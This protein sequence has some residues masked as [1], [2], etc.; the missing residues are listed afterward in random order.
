MVAQLDH[1]GWVYLK[2]NSC[3]PGMMCTLQYRIQ[4]AWAWTSSGWKSA[5]LNDGWVYVYPYTGRWRWAW[6]Q[7]TGWL[8]VSGGTFEI[9]SF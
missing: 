7:R 4:P 5:S 9:R 1:V 3:P 2:N 6:T 8:A